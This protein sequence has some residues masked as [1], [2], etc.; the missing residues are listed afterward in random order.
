MKT[1]L[2]QE[3]AI[4]DEGMN[5]KKASDTYGI[6]YSTFHEW[7]YGLRKSQQRGCLGILS[8]AEEEEIVYYI[9]RMCMMG[10]GLTPTTLKIK[11]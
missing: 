10:Y 4:V 5:I 3:I 11:V 2:K 8:V 1:S 9:V 7:C 6:P